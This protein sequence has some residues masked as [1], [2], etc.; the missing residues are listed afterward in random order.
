LLRPPVCLARLHLLA[1]SN[2]VHYAPTPG[3]DP[4]AAEV[5]A[6]REFV[7]RVV[8]QI[9]QPRTHLV[10]YCGAAMRIVSVITA[11]HVIRRI[12]DHLAHTAASLRAPPRH[13]TASR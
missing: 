11:P 13:D 2:Q 4:A 5:L 7:V 1:E 12:L 10:Q 8:T 6:P 9:P 3:H